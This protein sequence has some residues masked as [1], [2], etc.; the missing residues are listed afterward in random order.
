MRPSDVITR[1]IAQGVEM[2]ARPHKPTERVERSHAESN[3]YA[4]RDRP[5]LHV[6]DRVDG[7]DGEVDWP[8]EILR[9]FELDSPGEPA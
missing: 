3:G 6:V 8:Q 7:P 9:R 2:G 1:L 4:R 5:E